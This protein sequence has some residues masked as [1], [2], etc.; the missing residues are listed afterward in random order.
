MLQN[1]ELYKRNTVPSRW[2]SWRRP[3]RTRGEISPPK[4]T[5]PACS[6]ARKLTATLSHRSNKPSKDWLV[7]FVGWKNRT[8]NR[9]QY[10]PI[11]AQPPVPP[12]TAFPVYFWTTIWVVPSESGS[13]WKMGRKRVP[14]IPGNCFS[15]CVPVRLEF[16][17][18]YAVIATPKSPALGNLSVPMACGKFDTLFKLQLKKEK[19]I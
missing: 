13:K 6:S 12:P 1:A 17:E 14:A 15:L 10:V 3:E 9:W 16:P 7:V 2:L 18:L 4:N 11:P 19:H 5:V 8:A